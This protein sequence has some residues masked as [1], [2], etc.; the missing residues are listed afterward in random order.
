MK[1]LVLKKERVALQK[2]AAFN[3]IMN[4]CT[5]QFKSE[6]AIMSKL[7]DIKL[8]NTFDDGSEFGQNNDFSFQQS[9]SQANINE[10]REDEDVATSVIQEN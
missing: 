7:W 2:D 4:F 1:S 10:R 3:D 5:K 6:K 8:K 9:I